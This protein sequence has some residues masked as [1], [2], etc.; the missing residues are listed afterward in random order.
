MPWVGASSEARKQASELASQQA[1]RP[2]GQQA[3][4]AANEHEHEHE[5]EQ[6]AGQPQTPAR[7]QIARDGGA[8]TSRA[9]PPHP[10][11]ESTR[12]STPPTTDRSLFS[13]TRTRTRTPTRTPTPTHNM[14]GSLIWTPVSPNTSEPCL[15]VDEYDN[16]R[17]AMSEVYYVVNISIVT[18]MCVLCAVSIIFVG[19]LRNRSPR[20]RARPYALFVIEALALTFGVFTLCLK[21]TIGTL[22]CQVY[23]FML[24]LHIETLSSVFYLR[25]LLFLNTA[26]FAAYVENMRVEDLAGARRREAGS[27][28]QAGGTRPLTQD[29]PLPAGPHPSRVG[30]AS[31]GSPTRDISYTRSHGSSSGAPPHTSSSLSFTRSVPSSTQGG[32]SSIY[33]FEEFEDRKQVGFCRAL[34]ALLRG[35]LYRLAAPDTHS[36]HLLQSHGSTSSL[37]STDTS[38]AS[39]FVVAKIHRDPRFLTVLFF[40]GFAPAILFLAALYMAVPVFQS[41]EDGCTHCFLFMEVLFVL[42]ATSSVSAHSVVPWEGADWAVSCARL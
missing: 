23:P 7:T 18:L 29:A 15:G 31:G 4:R 1:T 37:S 21:D 16:A 32:R 39:L 5:Q 2:T 11:S 8:G 6:E 9:L 3:Q 36:R 42:L 12:G 19:L 27:F 22:P 40:G 34:Y 41:F 24:V 10:L 13:R 25:L 26:S 20:L 28:T 30:S 35:H 38:E 33:E 17:P 14:S